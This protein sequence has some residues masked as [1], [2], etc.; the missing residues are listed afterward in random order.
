MKNHQTLRYTTAQKAEIDIHNMTGD[1]AK[2]HLEMY[3]SRLDG[4]VRELTV[5]HGYSGGTV[6]RDM[7]RNSLRHPRI[8]SRYASLNPGVT[9]L[10]LN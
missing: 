2:R 1:Q 6:L 3:L 5:I 4:S 8:R 9:I 7:V 10:V